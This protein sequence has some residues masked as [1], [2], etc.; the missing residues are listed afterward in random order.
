M[1]RSTLKYRRL[2]RRRANASASRPEVV[3]SRRWSSSSSQARLR[4]PARHIFLELGSSRTRR[5]RRSARNA[6]ARPSRS[7]R[8][9]PS[10]AFL[11]VLGAT[12]SRGARW[13][14][15]LSIASL[16]RGEDAELIRAVLKRLADRAVAFPGPA[17]P[18]APAGRD[19]GR[20]RSLTIGLL[21]EQYV[22]LN[23]SVSDLGGAD[24]VRI[25]DA[26]LG[27]VRLTGAER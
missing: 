10:I 26:D 12:A 22:L 9:T 20:R 14:Y 23:V 1:S 13:L 21:P 18:L 27:D 7:P 3:V 25:G 8:R 5:S 2:A 15:D 4:A 11:L 19:P 17:A 24:G 16:Q 6:K